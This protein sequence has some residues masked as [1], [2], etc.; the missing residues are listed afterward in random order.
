MPPRNTLFVSAPDLRR[1]V[2]HVGLTAFTRQ[3]TDRIR[4]D[5]LRWP[6]FIKCPRTANHSLDGVIELMPV[7]D[8]KFFA[9]KYVNGHP[10]NSRAGIPSIMGYGGLSDFSNGWP[11]MVCEMTLLT[12]IRTAAT[13]LAAAQTLANPEPKRM[14]MIGNGAQSE[15]Q[16]VA[17]FEQLG[18]NDVHLYDSNAAATTKLKNNLQA[19]DGLNLTSHG[20]VAA[21]VKGCQIVTTST[22]DKTRAL[23][24]TPEMIEPG[25]HINAV[26]GDCP[27]KTELHPDILANAKVFVEFEEQTRIEGEIQ[28]MPSTFPVTELWQ[29]L[30]GCKPGRTSVSEIT[31]FDSVGFAVEDLS[32][33]TLTYELSVANGIGTPIDLVPNLADAKDLYGYLGSS[34]SA[35]E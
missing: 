23:I 16:I 15:F 24:L 7:S 28:Q 2:R 9:F 34:G 17:F 25:M 27:G 20:S 29:V 13:S 31:V 8:D 19:I 12:A 3:L 6:E 22:A 26:G 10:K 30:N 5:F 35:A 14:A 4:A 1:L 18:V 33:L 11:L 32:A 21:A